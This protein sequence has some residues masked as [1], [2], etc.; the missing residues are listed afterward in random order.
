MSYINKI[1]GPLISTILTDAA[2]KRMSQGN[3]NISYFQV[4]DSEVSYNT[5]D[6]LVPS[7]L[8]VLM[9]QYNAQNLTPA[10]ESNRHHVKYPLFLDSTSGST[11]G[12][13][14]DA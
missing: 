8:N 7:Q 10:P 5:I 12:I 3:F 1:T 4:G 2:R 14:Y 11:Y 9:P 6:N 13:P